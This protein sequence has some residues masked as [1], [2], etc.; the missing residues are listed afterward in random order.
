[1][2]EDFLQCIDEKPSNIMTGIDLLRITQAALLARESAD[3]QKRL[4]FPE[5]VSR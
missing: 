4:V 5:G 1:M 3:T 2:F